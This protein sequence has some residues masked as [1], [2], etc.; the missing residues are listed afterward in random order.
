MA[1]KRPAGLRPPPSWSNLSYSAQEPRP[2][3]PISQSA[4]APRDGS[5]G[6][7]RQISDRSAVSLLNEVETATSER[8]DLSTAPSAEAFLPTDASISID[9]NRSCKESRSTKRRRQWKPPVTTSS[10]RRRWWWTWEILCELLA[11]SS[12]I[13]TALVLAHYNNKPQADWQ[14]SY[15]TLNGLVAFLATLIKTGL[16]IPVSAAIGQRKWL[17]FLP[18]SNGRSRAHRLGEFEVFDEASRGSL[19]STKMIFA[20]N[21]WYE[22]HPFRTGL[23][24]YCVN[25]GCRVF[26]CFHH[27]S[28]GTLQ[29]HHAERPKHIHKLARRTNG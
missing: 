29:H 6:I 7:R 15:F 27:Y 13:A 26:R 2:V 8:H 24:A 25:Q 12:L 3:S 1:S 16:I 4:S 5:P 17:R 20:V 18:D 14:Q 22:Y 10:G 11:I 23:E 19:G 28:L 9:G 21:A